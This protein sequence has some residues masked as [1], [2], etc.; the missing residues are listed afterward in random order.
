MPHC[1]NQIFDGVYV[2]NLASRQDR[3]AEMEKRFKHFELNVERANA[4]PGSIINPLYAK[5]REVNKYFTNPNY[6]A[7]AISHVQI[8]S[9]ALAKGQTKILVLEDD[10]RIHKNSDEMTTEFF[11]QV[12]ADWDLIYFAY[13]PLSDDTSMWTYQNIE[14]NRIGSRAVKAHN[15]W[16]MM[17]YAMSERMMKHM[18]KVYGGSYPMEIDRYLV[19]IIQKSPEFKC[20]AVNPQCVA[21]ENGYSDNAKTTWSDISV[22][23]VDSRFARFEDY[24]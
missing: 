2:L 9:S 22:K 4:I 16:S 17:G 3:M 7:C 23:S 21:G 19:E 15:L 11:K 1:W 8:I 14:S 5:F 13:I 24:I 6:L 20:Y 10:V 12:P 18:L